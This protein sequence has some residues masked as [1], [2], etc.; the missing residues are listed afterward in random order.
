MVPAVA[1]DP[2]LADRRTRA[3]LKVPSYP[4]LAMSYEL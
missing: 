4:V 1:R 3:R 2:A